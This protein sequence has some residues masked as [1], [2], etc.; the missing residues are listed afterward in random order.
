MM[1]RTG[2][3]NGLSGVGLGRED[4]AALVSKAMPQKRLLDNSPRPVGKE[5]LEQLFRD[6]I[7]YWS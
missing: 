2:I 6:A 5:D 4:I 7:S 1:K 3:P